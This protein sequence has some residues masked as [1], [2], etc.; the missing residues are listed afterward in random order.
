MSAENQQRATSDY[1]YNARRMTSEDLQFEDYQLS[2][3]SGKD[4]GVKRRD[5]FFSF[6]DA[7]RGSCYVLDNLHHRTI[8]N[9]QCNSVDPITLTKEPG[10]FFRQYCNVDSCRENG[11]CHASCSTLNL[12]GL[13][14]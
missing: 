4:I 11:V 6:N 1:K 5:L 2:M 3:E 12:H 14:K 10:K 13:F 8:F 7:T 9:L